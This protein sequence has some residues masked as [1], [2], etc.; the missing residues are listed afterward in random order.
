LNFDMDNLKIFILV[1]VFVALVALLYFFSQKQPLLK[2]TEVV[3]LK[4]NTEL[5]KVKAEV[6]NTPQQMAKGLMFRESLSTNK[7]MLFVYTDEQIRSFWMKN[8]NFDIDIIFL[9]KNRNIVSIKEKAPACKTLTCPHYSSALPAMYA[10][11]VISG[12][13]GEFNLK[14][15]DKVFFKTDNL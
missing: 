7:A 1:F 4:G 12:F 6:V 2:T 3:F 5:T 13:A 11:E 8:M 14:I 9:D 10:V 15:G